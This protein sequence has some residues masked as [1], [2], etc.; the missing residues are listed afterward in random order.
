MFA[1]IIELAVVAAG[2]AAAAAGGTAG[3]SWAR[4]F[5]GGK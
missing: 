1:F 3:W 2:A 5:F 4:R